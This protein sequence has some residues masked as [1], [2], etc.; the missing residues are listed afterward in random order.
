MAPAATAPATLAWARNVRRSTSA[1]VRAGTSL[2]RSSTGQSSAPQAE[3]RA[4]Q[5]PLS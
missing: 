4:V 2:G 3:W 5:K 1:T